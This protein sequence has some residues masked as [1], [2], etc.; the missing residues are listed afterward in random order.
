MKTGWQSGR[1]GSSL[2]EKAIMKYKVKQKK[3]TNNH[4]EIC[5]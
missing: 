5:L 3:E 4:E 2:A 1:N